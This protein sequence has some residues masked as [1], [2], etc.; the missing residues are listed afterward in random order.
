MFYSIYVHI[1]NVRA[2]TS[3]KRELK[4]SIFCNASNTS[5]II[6]LNLTYFPGFRFTQMIKLL[7]VSYKPENSQQPTVNDIPFVP[8]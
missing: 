1:Y 4:H 2:R 8:A 5:L 7:F 3:V 6:V